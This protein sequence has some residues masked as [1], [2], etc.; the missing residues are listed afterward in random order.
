MKKCD[1]CGKETES[2]MDLTEL[3]EQYQT[4][5]VKDVCESCRKELNDYLCKIDTL[6]SKTT[7][8]IKMNYWQKVID[9][10]KR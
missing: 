5:N 2:F 7:R 4:S 1:L 10:L 8:Q 3:R 9:N 6:I